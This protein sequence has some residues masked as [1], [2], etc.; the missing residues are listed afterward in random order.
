MQIGIQYWKSFYSE[1]FL[2]F[3]QTQ[4]ISYLMEIAEI[5]SLLSSVLEIKNDNQRASSK[6]P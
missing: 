5:L 2:D 3:T 1:W 4:I 6:S